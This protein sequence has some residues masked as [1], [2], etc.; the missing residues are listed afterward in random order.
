M[1][2]PLWNLQDPWLLETGTVASSDLPV[3]RKE[4]GE[5]LGDLG[6]RQIERDHVSDSC[7]FPQA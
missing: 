3:L 7:R 4:S 2:P 5:E 6:V 1:F